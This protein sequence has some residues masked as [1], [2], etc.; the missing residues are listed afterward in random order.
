MTRR[1]LLSLIAI[2]AMPVLSA[3]H[4]GH[5]HKVMGVVSMIH[6]NH[7]EV[8][9]TKDKTSTFTLDEKTRVRRGKAILKAGDLKVGDRVVVVYAEA[10]DEKTGKTS[11]TVTEVQLGTATS[12]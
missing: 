10:K 2:F 5:T 3:A 6:E 7:L 9:D 11:V 1:T 4:P 12:Q 8:K